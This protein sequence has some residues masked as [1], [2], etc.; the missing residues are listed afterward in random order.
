MRVD[1]EREGVSMTVLTREGS[2]K[3]R[4]EK[5]EGR[6]KSTVRKE[7]RGKKRNTFEA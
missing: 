6:I 5:R 1:E 7:K 4:K 3:R 2:L